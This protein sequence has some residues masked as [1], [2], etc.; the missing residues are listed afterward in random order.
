MKKEERI[1]NSDEIG[2][3]VKM[4]QRVYSE[5]V[6]IYYRKAQNKTRVA[7]SV[8]KKFGHAVE[9]NHAKRVVRECLRHKLETNEPLDLVVVVKPEFKN[10]EYS[11]IEQAIIKCLNIIENKNKEA[12]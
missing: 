6:Y 8:S 11:Q 4:H 10:A 2:S 5:Y 3:I 1:K 7:I 12:K 9:R